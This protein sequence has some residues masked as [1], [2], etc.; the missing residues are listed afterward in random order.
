MAIKDLT[1]EQKRENTKKWIVFFRNN[2]HRFIEI[3][4]GI[5][6]FPYQWFDMYTMGKSIKWIGIKSRG[7]A[8]SWEAGLYACA[9]AVLY[10]KSQITIVAETKTQAGIIIDKK[11][12]PLY[13][14]YENL[15]REIRE[16]VTNAN[17]YEIQFYNESYIFVVPLR[18]SARG[19][20][21]DLIIYEEFRRLDKSKRDSIIAPFKKPRD[22]AYKFKPQ[23]SDLIEEPREIYITSSGRDSEDWWQDILPIIK[24][25]FV[26]N[27]VNVVFT[28][29]ITA[30]RY[31]LK[32]VRDVLTDKEK[33]GNE[34]FSMEYEN[35]L[36]R[37]N[38]DGFFKSNLFKPCRNLK[39][40]NYPHPTNQYDAKG[41]KY[42]PR[43]RDGEYLIMTVDIAMKSNKRNDNTIIKID[44]CVPTKNG[45]VQNMIY[46]EAM[47]GK[48]TLVQAL[49]IKQL[50]SDF[51]INYIILDTAGNGIGV[52][53]V[54]TEKT[55][56]ETRG[57]E[58]PP[59]TAMYHPSLGAKYQEAVE[60]T[61]GMNPIAVIYPVYASESMNSD[62]AFKVLDQMKQ[63]MINLPCDP[64]EGEEYLKS[65]AKFIDIDKD[66]DLMPFFQ[67]PYY[68]ATELQ[69]EM[70]ALNPLYSGSATRCVKLEEPPRGRK[71]RYTTLAYST[72]FVYYVLNPRINKE[73]KKQNIQ[74]QVLVAGSQSE[75]RPQTRGFQN[76]PMG[77]RN[78]DFFR[79]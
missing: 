66:M 11:I 39:L 67:S 49:R 38:K 64:L 78:K 58:Y 18:E 76:Q 41:N 62:C 21:S 74:E 59:F 61:K 8:K 2:V 6:L 57:I 70:C 60:R 19:N 73:A 77:F 69:A 45:F 3:Y 31:G 47:H 17:K 25:S 33:M 42:A 40:L 16:I 24:E 54:L 10:P 5:K 14:Q 13:D 68:Q 72:Y 27:D 1:P 53:D 71:D 35:K 32:T 22:A 29:Y 36:I 34:V 30:I 75:N 37:E 79:R 65:K 43:V 28:D 56:D 26:K 7:L 9:H 12:R 55:I 20:R 51:G 48:N 63:G 52:Y 15:N 23:Y 50:W 46:M 4:F 44:H